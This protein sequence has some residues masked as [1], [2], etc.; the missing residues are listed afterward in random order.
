MA[1]FLSLWSGLFADAMVPLLLSLREKKKPLT[2]CSF[3]ICWSHFSHLISFYKQPWISPNLTLQVISGEILPFSVVRWEIF[4]ALNLFW[5]LIT[6][7]PIHSPG[8]LTF[9]IICP[10]VT[11]WAKCQKVSKTLR[12][13]QRAKDINYFFFKDILIAKQLTIIKERK[14]IEAGSSTPVHQMVLKLH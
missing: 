7:L 9:L 2:I 12:M 14:K 5:S 1:N 6:T 11:K 4:T 3:S 8:T 13:S 10:I